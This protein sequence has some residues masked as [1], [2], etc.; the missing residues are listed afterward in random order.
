MRWF[1]LLY[2]I[3]VVLTFEHSVVLSQNLSLTE[4]VKLNNTSYQCGSFDHVLILLSECC[5][6]TDII[7]EPNTYVLSSSYK[8]IDLQN[9]RIRSRTSQ[10]AT[11]WCTL[12]TNGSYDILHLSELKTWSLN[13]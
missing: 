1:V 4:C 2:L 13:T 7:V 9:I 10:P 8:I 12:N 5:S 11:I 6:S 3:R